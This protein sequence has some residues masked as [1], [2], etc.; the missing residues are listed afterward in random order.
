[1]KYSDDFF[2]EKQDVK[3]ASIFGVL[4]GLVSGI[5]AVNDAGAAYIFIAIP[6]GNLLALKIDG[7]HHVITL[8]VFIVVCLIFGIPEISLV[9]LLICVVAALSD[10]IGH[11][12]ISNVTDNIYANLFFEYRFVMKIVIFLLAVCG[13]FNILVFICFLLFEAAYVMSGI[14]FEKLN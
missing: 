10:E 4:C 13:A 1:M 9:V 11:E 7:I 5:A 12:T 6:I 14:V 8:A 3:F 2:D